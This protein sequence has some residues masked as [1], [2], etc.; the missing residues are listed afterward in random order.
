MD[1][2]DRGQTHAPRPRTDA[3]SG[4]WLVL[5][6]VLLVLVTQR[7]CAGLVAPPSTRLQI[8]PSPLAISTTTLAQ[9]AVGQGY[10]QSLQATGGTAPYTWS[11][12]SGQL[13]TGLTLASATGQ[14]VGTPTAS[15]YFSFTAQA[16]DSGSPAQTA[17][18]V[19]GVT[20]SA[21][22][23][24]DAYGGRNDYP[25]TA[26]GYYHMTL[27][28]NGRHWFCTPTGHGQVAEWPDLL[29]AAFIT[30]ALTHYTGYKGY[31][32]P[33]SFGAG[34]HDQIF[35][36]NFNGAG[37]FADNQFT[38]PGT[39]APTDPT[40]V[41]QMPF[42]YTWD[43]AKAAFRNLCPQAS[44]PEPIKS[45]TTDSNGNF[46]DVYDPNWATFL[47]N[48]VTHHGDAACSNIAGWPSSLTTNPYLVVESV[49]ESDPWVGAGSPITHLHTAL[50]ILCSEP[51]KT[52]GTSGVYNINQVFSRTANYTKQQLI[53]LLTTEYGTI[54]ALNTAWGSTYTQFATTGTSVTG[55]AFGTGDGTTLTFNHTLAHTP[56]DSG[57]VAILV[58]GTLVL[59]DKG[60][61]NP[62]NI[63]TSNLV[64]SAAGGNIA[65]GTVTMATGAVSITFTA[66]HAPANGAAITVN[67]NYNGYC[68]GTGLADE[69]STHSW[70][71]DLKTLSGETT[72]MQTDM[73][74][75]LSTVWA[76]AW[77]TQHDAIRAID[78]NHLIGGLISVVTDTREQVLQ[79]AQNGCSGPCIDVWFA[80]LHNGQSSTTSVLLTPNSRVYDLTGIPVISNNPFMMA[81]T[82]SADADTSSNSI[83]CISETTQ[84]ARGADYFQYMTNILNLKGQDGTYPVTG[85]DY[86][87]LPDSNG[88]SGFCNIPRVNNVGMITPS[89]NAYNGVEPAAGTVNCAAPLNTLS[90]GNEPTPAGSG[91]RPFGN[92]IGD[93]T[94]GVTGG[95][96]L[97]LSVSAPP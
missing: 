41:G 51:V 64:S 18:R 88:A 34:L 16:A 86:W 20:V 19:F 29:T 65:S 1:N 22:V 59:G 84:A 72:V 49:G 77:K 62:G 25:C 81:E 50:Y 40:P 36:W 68:H 75:L 73:N 12:T 43:F 2:P 78:S 38:G 27:F 90:C 74:T 14:L 37:F 69:C 93:A 44:V 71:G 23:Q 61:G 17:S 76:K 53:S 11:I 67:Y 56:V 45:S 85:W 5:L 63:V 92:F 13:P 33:Q 95:N 24:V 57:S 35:A 3:N 94:H 70:I 30:G 46:P 66:G 21:K 39:Q 58:G 91:V 47:S 4:V 48:Y 96:A 89:A 15:G 79:A 52:G 54:G 6:V 42:L 8:A 28:S 80:A 87:A 82:D 97:W 60:A 9:P 26:T 7:G 32:Y 55:E 83:D 10:S 31:T